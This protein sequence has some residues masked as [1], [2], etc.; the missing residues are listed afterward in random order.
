MIEKIAIFG[1]IFGIIGN[2]SLPSAAADHLITRDHPQ[3]HWHY[4]YL[5]EG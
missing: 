5:Q 2:K 1:A 4:R 3:S